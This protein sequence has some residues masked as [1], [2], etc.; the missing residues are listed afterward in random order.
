ME[1]R[2][3]YVTF[4][5]METARTISEHILNNKL[6]ACYNLYEMQSGYWWNAEISRDSEVTSVM[7]TMLSKVPEIEKVIDELHPYDVPCII[8]IDFKA[9]KEYAQW[10][11]D[12]IT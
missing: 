11:I 2:M 5:D 12:S 8:N 6:I 10:I 1:L 4:P 9:N 7:K 3:L